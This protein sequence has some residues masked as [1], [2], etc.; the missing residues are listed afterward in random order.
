[1]PGLADR[2]IEH[3][4]AARALDADSALGYVGLE[5]REVVCLPGSEVQKSLLA[6]VELDSGR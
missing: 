3:R 6:L 5:R 1:L 2:R 4:L